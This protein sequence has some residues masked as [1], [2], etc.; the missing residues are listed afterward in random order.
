MFKHRCNE[1]G[2]SVS[3]RYESCCLKMHHLHLL[4]GLVF[5]AGAYHGHVG[6]DL[7]LFTAHPDV[8]S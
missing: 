5:Q 6:I 7:Y 2:I 1:A 8:V 3:P 4:D